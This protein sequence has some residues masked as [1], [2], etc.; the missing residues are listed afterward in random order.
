MHKRL[1]TRLLITFMCVLISLPSLAL[2]IGDIKLASKLGQPLNA[3][4]PLNEL[5]GLQSEEII[6]RH[7]SPETYDKLNIER[8][9]V[10]QI[11]AFKTVITNNQGSI[12]LSTKKAVNEPYVRLL[13]HI[14]WP[15]GE[16]LKELTLLLD[17][18]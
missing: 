4:L 17:P 15:Q 14:L 13:V 5:N 6:V 9:A 11:I 12:K 7:A 2:S 3:Q 8:P 1:I 10:F 18:A 16:M